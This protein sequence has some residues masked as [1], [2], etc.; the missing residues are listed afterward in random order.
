MGYVGLLEGFTAAQR[1]HA[2][3]DSLVGLFEPRMVDHAGGGGGGE[4]MGG[5]I[6]KRWSCYAPTNEDIEMA[7]YS[8]NERHG[9]Q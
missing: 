1:E 5:G 6:S 4:G 7:R 8:V 9:C 3:Y 2:A